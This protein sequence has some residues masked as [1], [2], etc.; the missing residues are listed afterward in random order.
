MSQDEQHAAD[1]L[2]RIIAARQAGR[3]LHPSDPAA[4]PH[5][6]FAER[7]VDSTRAARMDPEFAALLETELN[8][9]HAQSRAADSPSLR[10]RWDAWLSAFALRLGQSGGLAVAVTVVIALASFAVFRF[11]QTAPASTAPSTSVPFVV[12]VA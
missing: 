9:Q 12:S 8:R 11:T 1:E 7:L 6:E 2:D 5:A 3:M 10:R 4:A